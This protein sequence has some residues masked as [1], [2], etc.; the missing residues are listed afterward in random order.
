MLFIR[1]FVFNILFYVNLTGLVLFGV[2]L[3]FMGRFGVFKLARAWAWSSLWLLDKICGVKIEIRGR[4]KIPQG[5]FII[6]PKHQSIWE[7]FVLTTQMPDFSYVLKRE[8]TWIPFFGWYLI[9][10]EQ[11]AIDRGSGRTAL[12]QIATSAKEFIA[13]GRQ[14]FIFPEGTRRA[15]DAPP[16]YKFGVAQIYAETGAT[17]LPAALNAGLFWPR[18]SFLRK[19]GTVVLEFLDPIPPGMTK[20]AFLRELENRIETATNRLVAEARAKD[21]SL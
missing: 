8:L 9:R 10:A 12:K 14:V 20:A 17:C 4:E 19:P 2:P 21:S 15:V 1:S 7:T 3:L 11:M 16:Q 18:R 13:Q 6:A 5:G